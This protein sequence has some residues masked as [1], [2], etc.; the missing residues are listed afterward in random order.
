MKRP[1]IQT[2]EDILH[3]K[4]IDDNSRLIEIQRLISEQ[5]AAAIYVED[6]KS[7]INSP[8]ILKSIPVAY[9]FACSLA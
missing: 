6:S 3:N 4:D 7:L 1:I 9:P 2:I 5:H 8:L